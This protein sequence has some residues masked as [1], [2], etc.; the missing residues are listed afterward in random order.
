MST[1]IFD[2]NNRIGWFCAYTP[3]E[4]I[5]AAGMSPVRLFGS[6]GG[7]ELADNLM[8]PN[9]CPFVRSCLAQG[10][11]GDVP[12]AVIFACC[13]DSMRRLYDA[14]SY[15]CKPD[16]TAL[17]DLPRRNAPLSVEIFKISLLR[18]AASLEQY[19]G[20]EITADGLLHAIKEKAKVDEILE[21][22][23]SAGGFKG[24]DIHK[25]FVEAQV[26]D[27]ESFIEKYSA[28]P[29]KK[30]TDNGHGKPVAVTGNLL[31]SG[32]LIDVIEE[33][34]G[35]VSVLD[36]CSVERFTTWHIGRGRDIPDDGDRDEILSFIAETYMSRTPCP[37]MLD[38]KTRFDTFSALLESSGSEGVIYVPLMFCDPYL[39]ELPELKNVTDGLGIPGLILQSDY[40]D[41][42]IGQLRTRIEAFMEM[43]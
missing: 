36:L 39:Y 9:I 2:D 4:L 32:R 28:T 26:M 7:S 23:S 12:D 31:K 1:G 33:C 34:G 8:G 29:A 24:S 42:N 40:Q 30:R 15:Y 41:E 5:T 43:L 13:C 27:P 21:H 37:R 22:F 6:R 18:L 20:R 10:L 25:L 14:W 19:T 16:F 11:E 35:N 38:R 17:I 3:L